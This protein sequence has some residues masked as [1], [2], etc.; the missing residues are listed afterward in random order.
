MRRPL[1]SAMISATGWLEK[2]KRGYWP[3]LGRPTGIGEGP[4]GACGD[5]EEGC[6]LSAAALADGHAPAC[7]QGAAAR[8]TVGSP[9]ASAI[10]AGDCLPEAGHA[11]AARFT[12]A[13]SARSLPPLR[14]SSFLSR[15]SGGFAPPATRFRPCGPSP[16]HRGFAAGCLPKASV[17]VPPPSAAWG[18]PQRMVWAVSTMTGAYPSAAGLTSH[19]AV[20]CH[21]V[22]QRS[23]QTPPSGPCGALRLGVAPLANRTPGGH[24]RLSGSLRSRHL[25]SP[26]RAPSGY[27]PSAFGPC[28]SSVMP[29]RAAR[30]E[31]RDAPG[32]RRRPA[33]AAA[34]WPGDR[35]A[36]DGRGGFGVRVGWRGGQGPRPGSVVFVARRPRAEARAGAASQGRCDPANVPGRAEKRHSGGAAG[37]SDLSGKG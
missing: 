15:F 19:R 25:L 34:S 2:H 21:R 23:V 33:S 6:G 14:G 5:G 9:R 37:A 20:R 32:D 12:Q 27:P 7:P 30:G 26:L 31:T 36:D 16:F 3:G 29:H 18:C 4:L 35:P 24:L 8:A 11:S 28:G 10:V 1:N 17:A 13:I 22:V